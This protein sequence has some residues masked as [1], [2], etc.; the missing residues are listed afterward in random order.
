MIVGV[1]TV[2]G[3]LVT[4]MPNG[5]APVAMPDSL[6]LP[7]GTQPAALTMG[8]DFI[9]VVTEDDRIMIFGRDGLFR[10]E[11]QVVPAPAPEP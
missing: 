4:R 3:L 7:E 10:Q 9:A 2:V 6:A 11:I 5:T 1:I 8:R